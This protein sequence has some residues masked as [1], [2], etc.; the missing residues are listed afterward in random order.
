MQYINIEHG[1]ELRGR[2]RTGKGHL[3][4]VIGMDEGG[5]IVEQSKI[6]DQ[7]IQRVFYPD[8]RLVISY[9]TVSDN[10]I[11]QCGEWNLQWQGGDQC[12]E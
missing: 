4:A 8:G 3:H 2:S 12:A 10:E 9:F 11:R 6:H 5:R 1:L 7:L